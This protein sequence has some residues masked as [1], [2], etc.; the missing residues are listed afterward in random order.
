MNAY[1]SGLEDRVQQDLSIDR[2]HSVASFFVS[3]IDPAVDK[4]IKEKI[5]TGL[6]ELESLQGKIAV[7]NA[8][9]AYQEFKKF[10]NCERFEKLA[11][12]GAQIQRP[13]WAS[14]GTKNPQY[15]DCLYVDELIG[16]NTVNTIPTKTL[17]AFLDHVL[18]SKLIM[19]LKNP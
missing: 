8:R 19:L 10:F 16:S 4:L 15:S 17:H 14:T 1:L 5:D 2:I 9:M 3:R 12:K 11:Q 7:D 18:T 6:V 13:L